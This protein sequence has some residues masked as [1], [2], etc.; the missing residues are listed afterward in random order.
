[1]SWDRLLI[2]FWDLAL[3]RSRDGKE[4][5]SVWWDLPSNEYKWQSSIVTSDFLTDHEKHVSDR[6]TG[7]VAVRDGRLLPEPLVKH[8][9]SVF[10]TD[11]SLMKI[12]HSPPTAQYWSYPRTRIPAFH[13]CR[14]KSVCSSDSVIVIV[15]AFTLTYFTHQADHNC[16]FYCHFLCDNLFLQCEQPFLNF[17]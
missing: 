12:S 4:S 1:M 2:F 17:L 6:Q 8:H 10:C 15:V 9:A 3:W 13:T 5:R 16:H 7:A 14:R 11:Q